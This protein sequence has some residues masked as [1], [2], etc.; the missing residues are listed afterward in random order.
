M[1][2][3]VNAI[4]KIFYATL[5]FGFSM[6]TQAADNA[7]IRR[8][9]VLDISHTI[10]DF[11]FERFK[12]QWILSEKDWK[13][14]WENNSRI[15][16]PAPNLPLNWKSESVLGVFWKSIDDVVRIPTLMGSDVY[17]EIGIKTLVLMF[18]LNSPC[19]GIITDSSPRSFVV[20][21]HK[22][23]DFDNIVVRTEKTKSVGCF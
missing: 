13:Q 16:I 10:A 21:D 1:T 9:Q 14:F 3:R 11:K 23:S 17:E 18:T 4:C 12:T 22:M 6:S 8:I 7:D 2:Y 20:I 19:M 15:H 5:L